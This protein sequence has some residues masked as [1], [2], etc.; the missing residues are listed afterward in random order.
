MSN[1]SIWNSY[2]GRKMSMTL[3]RKWPH[4]L[5]RLLLTSLCF[6]ILLPALPPRTQ[7]MPLNVQQQLE[8]RSKEDIIRKWN[9]YKPMETGLDY[10]DLDSIYSEM[11]NVSPPYSAGKIKREYLQDGLNATNFVRFLAGLPDDV[12]LDWS[13]ELQQQTGA[14]VNAVNDTITHTPEQPK[15]MSDA[16]YKLGYAATSSSNLFMGS[17]TFYDNVLG[18]MSD[19]D[20]SNI[21]R[22][23]HRRWI[24]NPEMK[25]SMFGMVTGKGS[26]HSAM[27][28]FNDDRPQDEVSYDYISWPSA[29]F[30]P[31]EVFYPSD[32]W[33][34][35][36]NPAHYDS[37]RTEDITVTL[38]RTRDS[39]KWEF[40][41]ADDDRS[42]KY[43]NV[44]LSGFGIP[45]TVIFRPDKLGEFQENDT[46]DVQING[47]YTSNGSQ[48]SLQ[49]TTTFFDLLGHFAAKEIYMEIGETMSP[50][51][52][53]N[54]AAGQPIIESS[55]S[56]IVAVNK[57]GSITARSEGYATLT[58]DHYMNNNSAVYIHVSPRST[59]NS[60]SSWAK[61]D[62]KRVK[63]AGLL[64][65][66]Y[67]K[68]FSKP[69]N[70]EDFAQHAVN[71][72]EIATG[73]S[74]YDEGLKS[75]FHDTDNWMIT[76]ANA[77]GIVAGT[78]HNKFSPYDRISR[79]Q[80]AKLLLN[81]Y[82]HLSDI[83][84]K[85]LPAETTVQTVFADDN[86]IAAWA[87][88]DVYRA[89]ELS[90]MNGVDQNRFNPKGSLTYEQTFV[91]LLRMFE[92][93]YE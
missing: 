6:A 26:R 21:D 87:K 74:F 63:E 88:H 41:R 64:Y 89:V 90:L 62:I 32:A 25:K 76:W 35:S 86:Q 14:L 18:Y 19:S 75:P 5:K 7:A 17:P 55:D 9:L 43:F 77:N 49:Y 46:F 58:I 73:G 81:I 23:G 29:G 54:A 68:Q 34:V 8:G 59:A 72:M 47:L 13:L 93:F 2:Y 52:A 22:V 57:D 42:G 20:S 33:S 11:P 84:G 45:F 27:Y 83:T 71:M 36:L 65:Q 56:D 24:L 50:L 80:A 66:W 38:I 3:H 37:R 70:R 4:S 44:E 28:V 10:M 78:G 48:A 82:N 67:G 40:T 30:F 60:I 12:E 61:E 53:A 51:I 39:K 31:S 69:I 85:E 79:E 92:Q 16:M 91:I 1:S 15:S